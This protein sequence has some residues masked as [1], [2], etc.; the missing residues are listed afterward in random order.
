MNAIRKNTN[1]EKAWKLMRMKQTYTLNEIAT[2]AE[3]DVENIRHYHACLV[4]A[5]YA[6]KIGEKR[7]EGRPGFDN[8]YR[9]V[10]NT[11]PKPPVQKD[12]RFIFDPNN[13]EYWGENPH[14]TAREIEGTERPTISGPLPPITGKI[15]LGSGVR[16]LC[17]RKRA[18]PYVD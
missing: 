16:L 11:G 17:R 12:L 10:K 15:K 3:A 6:R 1:R 13:G 8:V 9:L 2:L 5:G 14:Q 4:L 7:Q 18:V